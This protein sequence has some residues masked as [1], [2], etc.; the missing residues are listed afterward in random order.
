[1]LHTLTGKVILG[2][3]GLLVAVALGATFA[4]TNLI[5][6][7][8]AVDHLT[9]TTVEQLELSGQF[10]TD[11]FRA[12]DEASAFALSHEPAD[13]DEAVQELRDAKTILGQLGAFTTT[14]D[15]VV[16]EVAGEQVILQQRA[17]DRF[18]ECSFNRFE[19]TLQSS[20]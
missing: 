1:M 13:R 19:A 14:E 9:S 3:I 4:I 8:Q 20:S 10:N 7:R 5:V 17:T 15:P 2:G 12:V 11:I 16:P 18:C 6:I